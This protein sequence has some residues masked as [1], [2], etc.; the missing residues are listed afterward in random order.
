MSLKT[1]RSSRGSPRK[2]NVFA[3]IIIP[4]L[5]KS[6]N[7]L[8]EIFFFQKVSGSIAFI[9]RMC[10]NGTASPQKKVGEL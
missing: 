10:Y 5:W 1:R 2:I 9:R 6:N 4:I 8:Q 7:F 3:K